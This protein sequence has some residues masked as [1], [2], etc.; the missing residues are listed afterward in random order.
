MARIA[1]RFCDVMLAS[2]KAVPATET[3]EVSVPA[4]CSPTGKRQKLVLDVSAEGTRRL[5]VVLAASAKVM[6]EA[7]SP[8]YALLEQSKEVGAKLSEQKSPEPKPAASKPEQSLPE[9]ADR[10]DMG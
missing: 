1:T 7:Y 2:G 5:A 3:T 9:A 6:G 4:E 10:P 8:F